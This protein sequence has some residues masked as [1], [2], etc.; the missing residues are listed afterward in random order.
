MWIVEARPKYLASQDWKPHSGLVLSSNQ[1]II[2]SLCAH[3]QWSIKNAVMWSWP[4]SKWNRYLMAG[5]AMKIATQSQKLDSQGTLEN[6]TEYRSGE[7]SVEEWRQRLVW[8]IT[9]I[10]ISNIRLLLDNIL[11]CRFLSVSGYIPS[12]FIFLPQIIQPTVFY[13]H[14]DLDVVWLGHCF[15][16]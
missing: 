13:V 5:F 6:S 2:L 16:M 8:Y 3:V 11:L 15:T 14:P 10:M 4:L 1:C 9:C 7:V 12:F